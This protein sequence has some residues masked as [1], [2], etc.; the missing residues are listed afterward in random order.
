MDLER[1]SRCLTG[2]W[3]NQGHRV[4]CPWMHQNRAASRLQRGGDFSVGEDFFIYCRAALDW[5]YRKGAEGQPRMM[6]ISL[7]SR[8][9]GRPGRF[10]ALARTL[11]HIRRHDSRGDCTAQDRASRGDFLQRMPQVI[12]GKRSGHRDA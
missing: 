12:G 6:T 11:D 5:L 1:V 9:I 4:R 3:C 7:H 8:I 10:G 2:F